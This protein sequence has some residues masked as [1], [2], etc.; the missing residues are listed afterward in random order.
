MFRDGCSQSPTPIEHNPLHP[1]FSSHQ[2]ASF[3]LSLH[4]F[5]MF[6]VLV[7]FPQ[8]C[9]DC[10]NFIL[11]YLQ[12]ITH[13]SCVPLRTIN[14]AAVVKEVV[15]ERTYSKP[16]HWLV[17][18]PNHSVYARAPCCSLRHSDNLHNPL[19]NG[20]SNKQ[21]LGTKER[22]QNPNTPAGIVQPRLPRRRW[23]AQPRSTP[24]K[25]HWYVGLLE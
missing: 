2:V 13:H 20:P 17:A 15:T 21:T 7:F 23:A 11:R 10:S 14:L 19:Q 6:T 16:C 25:Q 8:A 1:F 22:P 24:H 4:P 9:I 18:L 5:S 3:S 12:N